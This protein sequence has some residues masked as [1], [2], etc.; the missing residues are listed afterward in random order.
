VLSA[1][2]ARL[3]LGQVSFTFYVLVGSLVGALAAHRVSQRGTLLM[4]G[5]R[6]GMVNAKRKNNGLALGKQG[7]GCLGLGAHMQA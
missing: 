2:L 3:Q 7:R 4:A 6:V 1:L 5:V